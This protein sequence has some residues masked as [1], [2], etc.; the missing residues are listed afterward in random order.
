MS[1]LQRP[2]TDASTEAATGNVT[3]ILRQY[4]GSEGSAV[5]AV[6][7]LVYEELK[8]IARAQLRR[9]SM[10]QQMQ[11][12]M[13]VHEAY[14]KLSSSQRQAFNDRRH[15]FATAS[16]AMRQVVVDAYRAASAAKR[17]GG[18]YVESLSTNSLAD[19]TDPSH[20]LRLDKALEALEQDNPELAELID[21]S[22]FG[23][24]STGEIA[25]LRD[26][27]ERT[28]QRGLKRARAWVG[29]L[30]DESS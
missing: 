10:R 4:D 15:F 25:A 21:L 6:V 13:L 1:K 22:C 3:G 16:R 29:V 23:G 5:D 19:L 27:S 9:S 26:T 18:V 17:G 30:L 24:L 11:T 14:E 7:P 20:V 8:V 2:D 28:I 12:T